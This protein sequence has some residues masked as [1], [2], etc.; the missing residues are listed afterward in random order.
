MINIIPGPGARLLSGRDKTAETCS[1]SNTGMRIVS[2]FI[3]WFTVFFNRD[4]V[5]Q[6][7]LSRPTA[8]LLR[9]AHRS[10]DLRQLPVEDLLFLGIIS[11]P[12][13][14]LE[15]KLGIA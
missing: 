14:F 9:G 11:E 4:V 3:C 12:Q 2:V 6:L 10:L 5:G 15:M 13:R 1:P 7:E 8:T